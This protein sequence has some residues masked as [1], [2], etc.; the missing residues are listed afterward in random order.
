MAAPQ[1]GGAVVAMTGT[2][3]VEQHAGVAVPAR[4]RARMTRA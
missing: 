3:R 1:T 2:R 4:E